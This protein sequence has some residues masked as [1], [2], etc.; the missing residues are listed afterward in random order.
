MYIK[1]VLDKS[2]SLEIAA[3][4]L[5]VAIITKR[6]LRRIQQDRD[7]KGPVEKFPDHKKI[8]DAKRLL[9]NLTA[10]WTKEMLEY[11]GWYE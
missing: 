7:W 2:K 10:I 5:Q 3:Y 6:P 4:V 8:S 9:Y 1:Q 11:Y